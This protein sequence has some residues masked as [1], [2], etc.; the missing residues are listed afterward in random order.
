MKKQLIELGTRK[1]SKQNYSH[2]VTLPPLWIQNS[3][4]KQNE[5][6]VFLMDENNNLIIKSHARYVSEKI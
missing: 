5:L 6:I 3:G 4:I 1:I 2:V